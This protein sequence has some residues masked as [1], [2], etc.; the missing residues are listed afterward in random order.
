MTDNVE[1][2]RY[3]T[4]IISSV[5]HWKDG[6]YHREDGPAS[7]RYYE[8]G[9]IQYKSYW[10]NGIFHRE[11][12]PTRTWYYENG[13]IQYERYIVHGNW[14]RIDGPARI[15]YYENGSIEVIEYW[16]DN[17]EIRLETAQTMIKDLGIPDDFRE[18]SAEHKLMFSFHFLSIFP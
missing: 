7:I 8:N 11:I 3:H 17:K 18:W 16:L 13:N 9:D 1:I 4:G 2:R 15:A 10:I 6:F 5:Q 14:H 12:Y